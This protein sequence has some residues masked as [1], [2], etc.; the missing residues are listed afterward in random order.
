MSDTMV[1]V[2]WTHNKYQWTSN[3]PMTLLQAKICVC[4][5]DDDNEKVPLRITNSLAGSDLIIHKKYKN[6]SS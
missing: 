3:A 1:V 6:A 4:Y 5:P 2:K